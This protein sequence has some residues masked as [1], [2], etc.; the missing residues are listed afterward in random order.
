[1][2]DTNLELYFEVF[3]SIRSTVKTTIDEADSASMVFVLPGRLTAE[4]KNQFIEI[5]NWLDDSW[6][7][8]FEESTQMLSI[9]TATQALDVNRAALFRRTYR[10]LLVNVAFP[11]AESFAKIDLYFNVLGLNDSLYAKLIAEHAAF[12]QQGMSSADALRSAE[13]I[14]FIK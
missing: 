3:D 8:P 9:L 5:F 13:A 12:V 4:N 6:T 1:M 2:N 10:W 11:K 14:V 7:F